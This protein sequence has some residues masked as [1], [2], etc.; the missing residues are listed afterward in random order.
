MQEFLYFF[1]MRHY[2]K[3][4]QVH[5][6]H[7]KLFDRLSQNVHVWHDD[8]LEV[9]GRWEYNVGDGPLIP[10]IYCNDMSSC[11]LDLLLFYLNFLK[12]N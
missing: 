7:A 10:I 9:S 3:F 12:C 5:I 4:A 11:C 8:V 6:C 2:K 1:E